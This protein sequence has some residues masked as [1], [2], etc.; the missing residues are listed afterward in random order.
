LQWTEASV[1]KFEIPFHHLSGM[2]YKNPLKD[3]FTIA[4]YP[5]KFS[6]E[7]LCILSQVVRW[8]KNCLNGRLASSD[9]LANRRVYLPASCLQWVMRFGRRNADGGLR[10]RTTFQTELTKTIQKFIP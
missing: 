6:S 5:T 10:R 9:L 1:A 4:V 7:A 8:K 3:W 2:T